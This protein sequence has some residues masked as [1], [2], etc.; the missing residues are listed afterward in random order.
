MCRSDVFHIPG[1]CR[2]I[3]P[4]FPRSEGQVVGVETSESPGETTEVEGSGGLQKAAPAL[5]TNV[6]G[7]KETLTAD[8]VERKNTPIWS[9]VMQYFPLA[10]AAVARVS[11]EGND[12]HNPGEPLGW[13]RSKSMDHEDCMARHL[14]DINT[15]DPVTKEYEHAKRN[16]WR[17]LAKLELL[18]E[19]RLGKPPSRASR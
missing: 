5:P 3:C 15:L 2:P 10:L 14:V 16:A 6:P 19:A 1:H 17:A 18:E 12:Q 8:P 13:D 4:P 7:E 9:G 11:K